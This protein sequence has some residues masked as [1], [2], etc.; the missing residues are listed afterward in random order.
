MCL[1][2]IAP[3]YSICNNVA[4]YDEASFKWLGLN[5]ERAPWLS[6]AGAHGRLR[7]LFSHLMM[8][9]DKSY[10]YQWRCSLSF[11]FQSLQNDP[12]RGARPLTYKISQTLW[13]TAADDTHTLQDLFVYIFSCFHTPCTFSCH[14]QNAA[15]AWRGSDL[16]NLVPGSQKSVSIPPVKFAHCILTLDGYS[17]R[18]SSWNW[19]TH[20]SKT[21]CWAVWDACCACLA[22]RLSGG[23]NSWSHIALCSDPESFAHR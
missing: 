3:T 2:W 18:C 7:T 14:D 10:E 1:W 12:V 13:T 4:F 15:G 5:S 21:C 6:L 9:G 8:I 17:L 22:A 20:L 16:L 11:A 19:N 23:I